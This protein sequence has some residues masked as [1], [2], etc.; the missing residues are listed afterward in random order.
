MENHRFIGYACAYTPIALIHAAGFTP[1]RILPNVD[2][3]DH[4]GYMLHDNLCP[5]VK[6]IL[7]R[8]MSNSIPK[9]EG[10]ILMNSCDAMRRLYD[11]FQKARPDI[12]SVLIDLPVTVTQ[13]STLFFAQELQRLISVLELWGQQRSI[14]SDTIEKSIQAYN[15]LSASFEKLRQ[16]LR[17]GQLKNASARLQEAYNKASC[18]PVEKTKE[19][20]NMLITKAEV[21]PTDH[22]I[23]IFLFGN[24]LPEPEAFSLFESCGASIIGEDMCTGS[25]LFGEITIN[26]NMDIIQNLAVSLLNR[27]PCARTFDG[28]DPGRLAR[29]IVSKA[30]QHNVKGVI[31]Y[32]VKFCDPYIA[33]LPAIRRAL[34]TE[35]IPFVFIEGDCTLRSIGQQKTRIEAFIEM[36]R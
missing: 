15:D 36:L 7:D 25:R 20:L 16:K 12:N 17:D 32:T 4:A 14:H 35:N 3:P 21:Q 22:G 26:S 19:Y 23:P 8:A 28:T 2:C 5:H 10:M 9:L 24:I 33:R 18:E 13:N 27:Q 30:K 34:K 1:Y 6:R 29:D 31:G 11:A